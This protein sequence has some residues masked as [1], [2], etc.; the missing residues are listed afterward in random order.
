MPFLFARHFLPL[1]RF[2]SSFWGPAVPI[3][4]V[5]SGLSFAEQDV[6]ACSRGAGQTEEQPCRPDLHGVFEA[7]P[8]TRV[9]ADVRCRLSHQ[10][11]DQAV[12]EEVNHSS[13]SLIC[14][15][16]QLR[17]SS[18]V[19]ART[20]S[21]HSSGPH[22]RSGCP[23]PRPV[24]GQSR[25]APTGRPRAPHGGDP[26]TCRGFEDIEAARHHLEEREIAASRSGQTIPFLSASR[27][28]T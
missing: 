27:C 23:W 10:Q 15:V 5:V 4:V 17:T 1:I 26:Y 11:T 16:L 19:S 12:S 22:H 20:S 3:Y 6:V 14:G 7:Q 2:R 24:P 9:H 25:R 13:F 18:S 28:S 8:D 21:S